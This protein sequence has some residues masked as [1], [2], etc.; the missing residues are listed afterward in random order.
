VRTALAA[1]V[2]AAGP[3]VTRE[4]PEAYQA[5]ID[6]GARGEWDLARTQMEEARSADPAHIASR[7]G[8]EL[9]EDLAAE[10]VD[11]GTA[12]LLFAGMR[13]QERRDWA[14][15]A[16]QYRKARARRPEYAYAV[17]SL[18]VA[19]FESGDTAGAIKAYRRALALNP[20]YPYTHN[21]LGLAYVRLGQDDR[22]VEEYRAAIALDGRYHKAYANLAAALSRLGKEDEAAEA[23]RNALDIAGGYAFAAA[24][25]DHTEWKKA[26]QPGATPPPPKTSESISSAVLVDRLAS[27]AW[28]DREDAIA[29]LRGRGDAEIVPALIEH[30]SDKRSEVRDAAVRVLASLDAPDALPLLVKLLERDPAWLVQFHAADAL[31]RTGKPAA[32]EALRK[33]LQE[34][35]EG[36]VRAEIASAL[37]SFH[38]CETARALRAALEDPVADVRKA[39]TE[40]LQ[41]TTRQPFTNLPDW[42]KWLTTTCPDQ[43]A[44]VEP[45]S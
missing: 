4:G 5:A 19:L 41:A 38:D 31:G 24:G 16:E 10:R 17:H 40:S 21:N 14:G 39:A 1:F 13:A 9:L 29:V 2:I 12:R 18:G 30:L 35:A 34:Q 28:P 11:A 3:A 23:Y 15:A 7:R 27:D 8:A 6:A 44:P 33:A 45:K 37:R 26:Q 20:D 32:A 22:A 42:D 36:N 25:L 43:T